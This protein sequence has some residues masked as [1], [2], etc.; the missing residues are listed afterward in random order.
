[1]HT[2]VMA[3]MHGHKTRFNDCLQQMGSGRIWLTSREGVDNDICRYNPH[4]VVIVI[5]CNINAYW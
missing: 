2:S 3:I 1:M 4:N 5:Q